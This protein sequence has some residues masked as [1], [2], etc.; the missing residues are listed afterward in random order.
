MIGM[1]E[2]LRDDK[3]NNILTMLQTKM[4]CNMSRPKFLQIRRE[5]D[6]ALIVQNN[7]RKYQVLKHWPW[8][9]LMFKLKPLLKTEEKLKEM[10]E[11][12]DNMENLKKELEDEKGEFRRIDV[13]SDI[14]VK[15]RKPNFQFC[16]SNQFY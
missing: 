12:K 10:Q 6:A 4:R 1:L 11:M 15:S 16:F 5:R 9:G 7:W 3:I 13:K 8:Q 14:L 2:D